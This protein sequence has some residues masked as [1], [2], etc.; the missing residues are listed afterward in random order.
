MCS[1]S[2]M[3][4]KR[5]VLEEGRRDRQT[6]QKQMHNVA[7]EALKYVSSSAEKGTS[8]SVSL[9]EEEDDSSSESEDDSS[10]EPSLSITSRM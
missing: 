4:T 1:R 9:D 6:P 5:L 10:S 7:E 8:L 3:G 2:D